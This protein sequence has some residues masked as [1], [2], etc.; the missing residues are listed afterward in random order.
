MLTLVFRRWPPFLSGSESKIVSFI[1]DRTIHYNRWW[2][3]VS[4][5]TLVSGY[6]LK[7]YRNVV[8]N[9][10]RQG[11]PFLKNLSAKERSL[12]DEGEHYLTAPTGLSRRHIIRALNS[13]LEKNMICRI[14]NGQ[15]AEMALNPDGQYSYNELLFTSKRK[16]R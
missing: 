7:E 10:Q 15:N 3:Y 1:Y 6:P 2:A 9:I 12:L 11:T 16:S 4:I 5:E 13:L 8:A 14:V